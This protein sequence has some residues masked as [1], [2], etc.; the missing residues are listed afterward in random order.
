M[1]ICSC[2]VEHVIVDKNINCGTLILQIIARRKAAD[3]AVTAAKQDS[4]QHQTTASG[5]KYALPNKPS[6]KQQGVSICMHV[7]TYIYIYK[8]KSAIP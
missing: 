7:H 5:D 1:C 4:V 3:A 2:V 8:Y 6:T